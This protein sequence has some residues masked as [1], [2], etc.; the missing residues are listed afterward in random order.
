[1]EYNSDFKFDLLR[2]KS[3]EE[4]VAKIFSVP[5]DK[6]EVKKDSLTHKTGNLFVEF[7][8]RN[9]PSGISTSHADYWVFLIEKTYIIIFVKTSYLKKLCAKY[10]NNIVN[11]GD[12]NTSNGYL[13][14]MAELHQKI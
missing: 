8:C 1:M 12:S 6:I 14:P 7:E 9:Q 10:K 13:I 2:G 5:P 3:G 11:G 4:L